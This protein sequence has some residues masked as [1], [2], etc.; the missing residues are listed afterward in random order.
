MHENG[1]NDNVTSCTLQPSPSCLV[2]HLCLSIQ[3][4]SSSVGVLH[5]VPGSTLVIPCLP[6]QKQ[7]SF[8]GAKIAW[9]YN[10]SLVPDYPESSE[11]LKLSPDGF[12][13]E[14]SPV[15]VANEGEYEC[16]I[17]QI[18]MEW[19][20]VHIIQVDVSSSYI[21]KVSEG[22]TVNLPCERPPS[23]KDQVHWYRYDKVMR[24]GTRKQLNPAE[25]G[26]MEDGD[27]LEWLFGPFEKDVTITL[28][29]VKMEDAGMYYCET[30]EEGRDRS[31]LNTIEL[32]VEGMV[33]A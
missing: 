9:K 32:I 25:T 29:G 16:V 21:L 14:I 23:S 1:T 20:K 30:A 11:Q 27:R 17:K 6:G 31:N 15:S 24:N 3:L 2:V 18:D 12:F 10:D 4:F 8:A 26:E 7:Q 33:G 28:Y 13:L 19:Q 5:G 22:S